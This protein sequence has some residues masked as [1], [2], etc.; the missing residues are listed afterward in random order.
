MVIDEVS[1]AD[2][3]PSVIVVVSCAVVVRTTR[4]KA[5]IRGNATEAKEVNGQTEVLSD[6]VG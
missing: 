1:A 3:V 4:K 5:N 2:V 6:I